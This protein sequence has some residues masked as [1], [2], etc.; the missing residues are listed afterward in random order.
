MPRLNRALLVCPT[1]D[2]G[3]MF[4]DWLDAFD[5]QKEKPAAALIVDSSS[6]DETVDK[7]KNSGFIVDVV[8]RVSFNH[9]RTRQDAVNNHKDFTYI[10]F[11]TQDAILYGDHALCEL[12]S[13][14]D[15]LDVAAIC[16]RQVPRKSAGPIEAHARLFTYQAESFTRT[17]DDRKHSGLKTAFLSNSFAAYRVSA[18]KEVGGFPADVIFGEDMYVA[19]KMLKAGYKIAYAADACVYHSHGYSIFQEMK[20]YFD[21]GVFHARE[22]WIRQELG[23]AEGEGIK[24]VVSEFRYLLKH[25]FW[26]V[27]E[28]MLRTLFR[29]MGFRLGLMEKW[30]PLWLKR[31]L[32]M[33][34]G[35]Y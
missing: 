17:Y 3:N 35:F 19:A 9:G 21:M 20:R 12:L 8:P 10:L 28:G 29:Y 16:G 26:K 32:A 1:L 11:L 27:P 4:D 34:K 13:A 30:I 22:P 5:S 23:T 31:R 24:F 14:F 33:N 2:P 18:L 15:D 6:I 7:A 25:A